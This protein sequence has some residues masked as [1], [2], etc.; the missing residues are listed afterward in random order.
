MKDRSVK[1]NGNDTVGGGGRSPTMDEGGPDIFKG[2]QPSEIEIG[3]LDEDG[4][5]KDEV[6]VNGGY[7]N[8]MQEPVDHHYEIGPSDGDATIKN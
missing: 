8:Y 7:K 4:A 1:F 3:V 6:T 2:K 5:K